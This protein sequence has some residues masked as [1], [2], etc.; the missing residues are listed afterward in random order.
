MYLTSL[1]H[2]YSLT[3]DRRLLLF[4]IRVEEKMK[5]KIL[6]A[7]NQNIVREGLCSL[8]NKQSDLELVGEARNGRTAID[9]ASRLLPHIVIINL[10]IP[11]LNGVE[12]AKYINKNLPDI[13]VIVLTGYCDNRFVTEMIKAGA[14]G[15]LDKD[16]S[17]NELTHAINVVFEGKFYLSPTV[18]GGVLK[19]Y[20]KYLT[21][22]KVLPID[23]LTPREHQVLRL[24]AEGGSM[25]QISSR[26]NLSVK[27]V[28][29]HRRK[30]MEKLNINS[31]A[32]LTKYAITEGLIPF[33]L[34]YPA[35][36]QSLNYHHPLA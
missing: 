1:P 13:K 20:L 27:T 33:D 9:L 8:I 26:L 32:E 19:D 22:K 36:R 3:T 31:V 18:T 10:Q 23:K 6:L 28:E 34:Q 25:K 15:Y 4:A 35:L 2:Y 5:I 30:V 21:G 16:C 12:A 17:F 7:E 24:I 29:I 14:R 11:E